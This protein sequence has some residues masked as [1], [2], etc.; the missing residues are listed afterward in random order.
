MYALRYGT[1]R[2]PGIG[3][4]L[5]GGRRIHANLYSAGPFN[6]PTFADPTVQALRDE[7]ARH[8]AHRGEESVASATQR[9]SDSARSTARFWVGYARVG[10][11]VAAA[12]TV[13]GIAASEWLLGIIGVLGLLASTR[14]MTL[15]RRSGDDSAP[16]EQT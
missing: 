13:V 9:Q 16:R 12:L 14:Q 10:F 5:R 2:N 7:L 1:L 8:S 6:R 11:V 15:R 4:R 3:F